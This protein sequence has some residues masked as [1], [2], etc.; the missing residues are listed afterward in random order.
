MCRRPTQYRKASAP[1]IRTSI[2]TTG[3]RTSRKPRSPTSE[4][5]HTSTSSFH[6]ATRGDGLVNEVDGAR[7][8]L[9]DQGAANFGRR[10][11]RIALDAVLSIHSHDLGIA[12]HRR[13]DGH[14]L[15]CVAR[16]GMIADLLAF[17]AAAHH[18]RGIA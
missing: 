14:H 8:I 15:G 1:K 11:A 3:I 12:H 13:I 7:Q 2:T 5:Y 9:I 17:D 4:A 6:G 10:T 16:V 18:D